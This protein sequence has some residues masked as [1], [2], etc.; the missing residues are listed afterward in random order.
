MAQLSGTILGI[1]VVFLAILGLMV[2][3]SLGG[4]IVARIVIAI[5][6]WTGLA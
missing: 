6:E 1:T 5:A 3:G 4:L 2:L